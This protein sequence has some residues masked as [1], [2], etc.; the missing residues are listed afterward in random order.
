MDKVDIRF[1]IVSA[2]II[3]LTSLVCSCN[4]SKRHSSVTSASAGCFDQISS[5]QPALPSQLHL[6]LSQ[7]L[8]STQLQVRLPLYQH[9]RQPQVRAISS[10]RDIPRP[11]DPDRRILGVVSLM[12]HRHLSNTCLLPGSTVSCAY[13]PIANTSAF[14]VTRNRA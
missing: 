8:I 10:L 14:R 5:R 4:T 13:R 6:C 11:L 7:R 1:I 9:S 2:T 3:L 12:A